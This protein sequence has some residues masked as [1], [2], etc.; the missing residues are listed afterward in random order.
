MEHIPKSFRRNIKFIILSYALV[1]I[2]YMSLRFYYM[3]S[4]S[5]IRTRRSLIEQDSV[6]IAP[7][8]QDRIEE[9]EE[10]EMERITYL[11]YSNDNMILQ[12]KL[13]S[14]SMGPSIITPYYSKATTYIDK[15]DIAISTIVTYDRIPV[16]S[17]LAS[18]YKGKKKGGGKHKINR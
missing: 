16:L 13:Y 18:R 12:S 8:T 5:H 1:N 11:D 9:D 3:T 17:R 15:E 10:Q 7:Y 2:I 14:G 6:F 4:E